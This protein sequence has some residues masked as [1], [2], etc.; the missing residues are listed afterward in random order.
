MAKKAKKPNEV[1]KLSDADLKKGLDEAY[2]RMF[3]LNLQKETLQLQNHRQIPATRREIA[4]LKTVQ[5]Q[6]Q[7]GKGGAA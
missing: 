3:S 2:K 5:R 7:L 4:R 6:R 1:V